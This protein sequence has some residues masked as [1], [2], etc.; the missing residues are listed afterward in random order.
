MFCSKKKRA[1]E[2]PETQLRE[3][4]RI[5][6]KRQ[7]VSLIMFFDLIMFMIL[8]II[9]ALLGLNWWDLIGYLVLFTL[10]LTY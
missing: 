10:H 8:L 5:T 9:V 2:Q 7:V 1:Y 6:S 3:I 4:P